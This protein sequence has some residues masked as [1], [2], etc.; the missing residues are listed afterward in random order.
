MGKL[1]KKKAA[2]KATA[3][4]PAAA[5]LQELS[6]FEPDDQVTNPGKNATLAA[7]LNAPWRPLAIV[8]V[9]RIEIGDRGWRVVYR[10]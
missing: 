4:A 3:A 6:L 7:L 10:E 2:A 5:P 8:R 9:E 1:K